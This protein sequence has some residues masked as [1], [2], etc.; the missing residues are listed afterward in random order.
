VD[1]IPLLSVGKVT[2]WGDHHL[3]PFSV[4]FHHALADGLHIARFIKY[5]EEEARALVGRSG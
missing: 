5:I 1:C 2:E 3:L 4:N